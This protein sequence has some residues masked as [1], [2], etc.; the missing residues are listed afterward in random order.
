MRPLK[1]I[2]I[3]VGI[4]SVS[5][6]IYGI[7]FYEWPREDPKELYMTTEDGHHVHQCNL[8]I[9][10]S[11]DKNVPEH[12][13]ELIKKSFDYWEGLTDKRLFIYSGIDNYDTSDIDT[14]NAG[15]VV[16]G[17]ETEIDAHHSSAG[18]TAQLKWDKKGCIKPELLIKL[19]KS[20]MNMS[21]ELRETVIR[22][23]IGHL[24]GFKD[25]NDVKEDLMY[26][27]L[28]P[29][30][31]LKGLSEWELEAFKIYYGGN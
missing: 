3:I 17:V 7:G 22:H 14:L 30:Y 31:D 21:D 5:L 11:I 2:G 18:G 13:A 27:S 29:V 26:R 19:H 9:F 28:V 24:L 25:T 8:P 23:E 6:L 4:L 1:I 12:I 15:I 20:I 16:I 10:Y